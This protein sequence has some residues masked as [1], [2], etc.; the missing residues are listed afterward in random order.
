MLTIATAV[1]SF[2]TLRFLM[3]T[4]NYIFRQLEYRYPDIH[5]GWFPQ[6]HVIYQEVSIDSN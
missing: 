2:A 1:S 3:L 6:L 4:T 5:I